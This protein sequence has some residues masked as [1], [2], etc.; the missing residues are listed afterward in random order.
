MK[1]DEIIMNKDRMNRMKKDSCMADD[2]AVISIP[3][4]PRFVEVTWFVK[5]NA[6]YLK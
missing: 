1:N 5:S 4:L 2:M 6:L 3:Y